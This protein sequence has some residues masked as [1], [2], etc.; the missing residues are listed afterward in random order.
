MLF[1]LPQKIFLFSRYL[2]FCL[3]FLVLQQNNLIR[4][5]KLISR[6][7]RSKGD[8]T[9]KFGQLIVLYHVSIILSR[10]LQRCEIIRYNWNKTRHITSYNVRCFYLLVETMFL[11][12]Q[13]K[14]RRK[15][16]HLE[17]RLQR[18]HVNFGRENSCY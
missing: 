6:F 9:M 3:Y 16:K 7:T 1:I 4:K 15:E 17:T 11:R 2:H 12:Y 10:L 14:H 13:N 5:I 8:Q 18:K